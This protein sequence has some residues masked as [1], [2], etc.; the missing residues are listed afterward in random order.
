MR[1]RLTRKGDI[2]IGQVGNAT[3]MIDSVD[4][5]GNLTICLG[6]GQCAKVWINLLHS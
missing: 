4:M 2:A 5:L 1:D 6:L 3:N